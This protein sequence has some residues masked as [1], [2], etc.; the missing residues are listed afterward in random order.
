MIPRGSELLR[1]SIL[2]HRWRRPQK[3][4]GKNDAKVPR[5]VW[6]EKFILLFALS[7]ICSFSLPTVFDKCVLRARGLGVTVFSFGGEVVLFIYVSSGLAAFADRSLDLWIRSSS[8]LL[9]N[10]G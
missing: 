3:P 2:G 7:L 8:S 10:W 9:N 4:N 5:R 6:R 1:G